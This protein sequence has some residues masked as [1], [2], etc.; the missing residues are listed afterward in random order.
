MPCPE[1]DRLLDQINRRRSPD[2]VVYLVTFN[3]DTLLEDA[4]PV[5]GLTIAELDHYI[6]GSPAY[7]VFK[8]HG[9]VNWARVVE[10]KP[11]RNTNSWLVAQENIE[12][13]NGLKITSVFVPIRVQPCGLSETGL[14]LVPAI[15]IP[16]EKKAD[17]ECPESHLNE[18]E[19]A[20]Q[21]S[22]NF[23]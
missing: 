17:F 9:S 6:L 22:T 20:L 2:E 3:Y 7:K 21:T 23:F 15:A 1:C 11:Y 16:V 10:T 14:G 12:R 5:V 18:L 4:T 19:R 13:A 8:L